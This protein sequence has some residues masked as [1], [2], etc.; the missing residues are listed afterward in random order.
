[1]SCDLDAKQWTQFSSSRCIDRSVDTNILNLAV[2]EFLHKQPKKK[3]VEIRAV[4]N[5][6]VISG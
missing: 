6:S 4:K 5:V 1:M 3:P 2:V